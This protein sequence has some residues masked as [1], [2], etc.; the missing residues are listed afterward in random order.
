MTLFP[1]FP[2]SDA[3]I[4]HFLAEDA[5]YG[6]LTSRSLGLGAQ[7]GRMR[8][9]ARGAM[10]AC[11]SE[12]AARLIERAGG[13]IE[14]LTAS[15][16]ALTPG[17]EI[18]AAT[19]PA[20]A[21]LMAWK[22]A[23][24][25]VETASGIASAAAAI[26]A[27]A[28]AERPEIVVACTRKAM[29]GT[30]A[31]AVKAILAGGA[32]PHRLGLSDS[33]LLFPEHRA[34]FPGQ[35]LAETVAR[36]KAAC[37]ERRVVVEVTDAAAAFEAAAAGAEVIQLEKFSPEAVAEVADALAGRVTIAAAGGIN[38]DNAAAYARAGADVLVTS[39]P[40]WAKPRDVAVSIDPA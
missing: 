3:E 40:Y 38:A 7:P 6:D 19:G 27:A 18:L 31:V 20:A 36:L 13:R 39:A 17:A 35:P 23:Q 34:F 15:G 4:E 33:L 9:A 11:A 14:R 8:F 32:T 2:L 5:P 25:L 28:R 30:R 1:P 29:P 22:V 12:E 26:V 10:V 21:L 24:T 37:P 16:T